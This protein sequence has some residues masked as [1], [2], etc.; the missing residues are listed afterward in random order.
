VREWGADDAVSRPTVLLFHGCGGIRP[1]LE[2]YGEAAAAAGCR[3]LLV[4]S[5]AHRG[6][7]RMEAV[8]TVCTGLRFWGR[9]RAGDVLA[10]LH[11]A[12]S[13]PDID[14]SRV[15]LAGWSHGA[16]SIM[17]LMTMPLTRAGE[18]AVKD[19]DPRL[20]D[21]VRALFLAYPYGG[22][23][24]LTRRRA[25]LRR[26]A[27]FGIIPSR[28]HVTSQSAARGLY[29]RLTDCE[30]EVWEVEGATHSFDEPTGV[31]PMRYDPVLL[32][33]SVRRF[34]E[35]VTRTLGQ[36]AMQPR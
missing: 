10:A 25:W 11:G 15:L 17:D 7:S 3:A 16:W 26:P 27:V 1:H 14:A 36:P 23:G 35:F 5:Y 31:P 21:G 19:P 34:S 2:R 28:D 32:D 24:A 4:D 33:E 29:R 30:L 20:L 22:F 8:S 18:A 9:E 13:R 12:H 6:W